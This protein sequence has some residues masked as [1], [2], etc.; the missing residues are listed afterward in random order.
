[1]ALEEQDKMPVAISYFLMPIW[2]VTLIIFLVKKD[3]SET[4]KFL[5]LQSLAVS[6]VFVIFSIG[7]SIIGV[8]PFI[9]VLIGFLLWPLGFLAILVYGIILGIQILNKDEEPEIPM[10]G[11]FVRNSLM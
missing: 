11:E 7:L 2:L 9:G 1:M 6:V 3:S 5:T 8:V 10:I 4:V